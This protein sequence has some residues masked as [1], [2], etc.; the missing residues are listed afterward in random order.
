MIFY[1]SISLVLP[2]HFVEHIL[3]TIILYLGE[4]GAPWTSGYHEHLSFWPSAL[5]NFNKRTF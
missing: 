1:I 5:P 2:N 4:T 3:L